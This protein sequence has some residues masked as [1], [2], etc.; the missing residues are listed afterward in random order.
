MCGRFTLAAE[1]AELQLTFGLEPTLTEW[2]PRFNIAPS[3]PVAVVS[4]FK[5]RRME[6]M[7]WGLIPSWAKDASI[8]NRLINARAETV[9]IKPSLRQAFQKRRCLVL[10][11]GFYEWKRDPELRAPSQPYYF[12]LKDRQPFAFA[13][14]WDTWV[15]PEGNTVHSC[16]LITCQANE[17]VAAVQA[18][19]PV[20]LDSHIA[21]DWLADISPTNLLALLV[22]YPSEKMSSG[23]VGRGV[24]RPENDD[25]ACI[26]PLAG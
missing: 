10:A 8:G 25:P 16:T 18:R 22:P 2:K 19:M 20:I 17:L 23:A 9:S 26:Q 11:N 24:N 14:L 6:L 4:Q 15:S 5:D 1:A 21:W 3:Q 12:Q 7:R 13:G